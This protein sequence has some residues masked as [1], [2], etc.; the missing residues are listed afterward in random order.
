MRVS[1]HRVKIPS[2]ALA[3]EKCF[4]KG[5]SLASIQAFPIWREVLFKE[6]LRRAKPA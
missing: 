1:S 5:S 3:R 2:C 4:L 6:A